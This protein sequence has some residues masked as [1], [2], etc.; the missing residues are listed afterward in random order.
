[1]TVEIKISFDPSKETF[2]QALTALQAKPVPP[3]ILH[4]NEVS[5]PVPAEPV[6][7][8]AALEVSA[9]PQEMIEASAITKTEIRTIATSL[10]KAGK[11]AE[12][13]AVFNAFG[14][15]KLSDISETDYPM[16]KKKLEEINA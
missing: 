13:K 8:Q 16:L 4:I 12:L 6:I 9:A 3:E 14:A 1:M 7:S 15:T 2:E 5:T 10:S 11:K